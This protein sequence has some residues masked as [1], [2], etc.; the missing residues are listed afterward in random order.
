MITVLVVEVDIDAAID[1]SLHE[2][3]KDVKSVS[4]VL[5]DP[6]CDHSEKLASSKKAVQFLLAK[7][8]V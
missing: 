2:F 7:K 6:L 1:L 3:S 5:T 4:H 8:F